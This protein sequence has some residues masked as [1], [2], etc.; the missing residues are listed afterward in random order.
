MLQAMNTSGLSTPSFKFMRGNAKF[1]A[2][3][4]VIKPQNYAQI[5]KTPVSLGTTP[6]GT[7]LLQVIGAPYAQ[8]VSSISTAIGNVLIV[9]TPYGTLRMTKPFFQ[10][11]NQQINM[12]GATASQMMANLQQIAK[13]Q[14]ISV[15]TTSAHQQAWSANLAAHK[16]AMAHA[17]MFGTSSISSPIQSQQA[18]GQRYNPSPPSGF[19]IFDDMEDDYDYL[20][21]SDPEYFEEH[22]IKPPDTE[23]YE[24]IDP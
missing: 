7:P 17:M 18:R 23:G 11:A 16:Q 22:E 5:F 15:P 6:V 19:M 21:K 20:D 4:Q 12:G 24:R 9:Q 8:G 2:G 3:Q 14:N 10:T 1:T 13:S